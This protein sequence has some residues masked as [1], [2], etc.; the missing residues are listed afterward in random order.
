MTRY[1]ASGEPNEASSLRLAPSRQFGIRHLVWATFVM[2]LIAAAFKVLGERLLFA[3]LSM[4]YAFGPFWA[5]MASRLGQT[6]PIRLV[7]AASV[8]IFTVVPFVV[9]AMISDGMVAAGVMIFGLG[10]VWFTETFIIAMA[11]LGWRSGMRSAGIEPD[12]L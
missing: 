10:L 6:R 3:G 5:F 4:L 2:A 7:I 8:G 1:G 9:V 12:R 11:F